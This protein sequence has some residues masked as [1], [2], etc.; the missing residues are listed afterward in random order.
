MNARER[1]LCLYAGEE[2]ALAGRG[3]TFHHVGE[4][5]AYVA[6]LVA[7]DWWA[8]HW[9]HIDTIPVARTRSERLSGYAVEGTGEI[10]IG[11]HGLR[12]PVVL[13][14]IAHVVT[15]GAGHGPEFVAALLALARERLGFHAYGA[16]LAELRH[17][18]LVP[19]GQG[20][21]P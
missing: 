5:R 20:V 13:H 17:R 3:R 6:E 8:D 10:R 1:Q 4:V 9:P 15:P 19:G 12:E 18:E 7:G 11:R 14:E 2:A 21:S 16:L